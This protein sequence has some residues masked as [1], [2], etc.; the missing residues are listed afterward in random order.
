MGCVWG[1]RGRLELGTWRTEVSTARTSLSGWD[2]GLA[3]HPEIPTVCKEGSGSTPPCGNC[4]LIVQAFVSHS[5]WVSAWLLLL[6]YYL[7]HFT[8]LHQVF[9]VPHRI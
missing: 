7:F 1:E 6:V 9:R 8:W 2:L 4:A 3:T 5:P